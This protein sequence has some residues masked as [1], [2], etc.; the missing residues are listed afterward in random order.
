MVKKEQL[1]PEAQAELNALA[2]GT[3][4][5][6]LLVKNF[7]ANGEND[8]S[9]R[10]VVAR[11]QAQYFALSSVEE[12][13][14]TISAWD[15]NEYNEPN[16]VNRA[17]PAILGNKYSSFALKDVS[18]DFE[19]NY[20][21]DDDY[22]LAGTPFISTDISSSQLSLAYR[23]L[24]QKVG[25]EISESSVASS[26]RYKTP[27]K[28]VSGAVLKVKNLFLKIAKKPQLSSNIYKGKI[29]LQTKVSGY[30]VSNVEKLIKAFDT[31]LKK[32]INRDIKQMKKLNKGKISP[33]V[34]YASR[35]F[36]DILMVRINDLGDIKNNQMAEKCLWLQFSGVLN[37]YGFRAEELSQITELGT[38]SVANTCA[39]FGITKD[40]VVERMTKLGYT[41][42]SVPA[43]ISQALLNVKE[44]N[45]NRY[46]QAIAQEEVSTVN[47]TPTPEPQ[48]VTERVT[49]PVTEP[50]TKK[51]EPQSEPKPVVD[52]T[53]RKVVT[54]QKKE[55][56]TEITPVHNEVADKEKLTQNIKASTVE[57]NIDKLVIKF[58]ANVTT[59]LA[60]KID[61]GKLK[62]KKLEKA[63]AQLRLYNLTL[64][65]YVQ[66]THGKP[67]AV[68]GE[69][70]ATEISKAKVIVK[71]L[72]TQKQSVSEMIVSSSLERGDNQTTT[73]YMNAVCK[74]NLNYTMRD[75]FLK[76]IKGCVDY[77]IDQEYGKKQS[78]ST[79][80]MDD[81]IKLLV[82]EQSKYTDYVPD[83]II[84]DENAQTTQKPATETQ[85]EEQ[86]EGYV[87]N[88]IFIDDGTNPK[89]DQGRV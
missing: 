19:I 81:Q 86:S 57:K 31:I 55:P 34:Q 45:Y 63:N 51:P 8:I 77:C 13:L 35:L 22:S 72:L 60:E 87:P 85:A 32:S 18:E 46:N 28:I 83:F 74:Q 58:L 30:N 68:K 38:M 21:L 88:F 52:S 56:T 54:E 39:E 41:Y 65:Y 64:A 26:T 9:F 23:Q 53:S 71:G 82:D 66:A 67:M 36:A 4:A 7:Y 25:I 48:R 12:S 44:K 1:T 59:T 27:N 5:F 69:Y 78:T 6:D 79:S 62:G 40:K 84:I 76:L 37:R 73:S 89:N 50:E 14:K 42:T 80:D 24:A 16:E 49:E 75:Y 3:N 20:P 11:L 70:T 61:G 10:D 33:E 2:K 17:I 29:T 15:Q 43:D 47:I